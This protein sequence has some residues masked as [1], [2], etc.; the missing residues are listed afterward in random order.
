LECSW[1][2]VE[3]LS[4]WYERLLNDGAGSVSEARE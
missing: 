4:P 3:K 1:R 2:Q